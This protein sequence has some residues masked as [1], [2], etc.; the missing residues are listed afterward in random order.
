MYVVFAEF[1]FTIY[2]FRFCKKLSLQRLSEIALL[3]LHTSS[4]LADVHVIESDKT[5]VVIVGQVVAGRKVHQDNPT[6]IANEATW[7]WALP[8]MVLH[9]DHTK[10]SELRDRLEQFSSFAILCCGVC[11][12]VV[13]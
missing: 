9:Q 3:L 4:L 8:L 1:L 6:V 7:F 10:L 13:V 12:T 5:Q 2:Y 11:A